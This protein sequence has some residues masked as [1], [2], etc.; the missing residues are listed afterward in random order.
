MSLLNLSEPGSDWVYIANLD[1][2]EAIKFQSEYQYQGFT[3]NDETDYNK[4]AV[5]KL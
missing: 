2:D 3:G 4:G 1:W 5:I